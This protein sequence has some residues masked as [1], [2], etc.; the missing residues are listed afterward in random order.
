VSGIGLGLTTVNTGIEHLWWRSFVVA[1]VVARVVGMELGLE[2]GG[3]ADGRKV[4]LSYWHPVIGVVM[5]GRFEVFEK[6]FFLAVDIEFVG[7]AVSA[8]SSTIA[9]VT[10]EAGSQYSI[11]QAGF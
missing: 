9:V 5:F 1:A 10:T 4:D 8:D 6:S 7:L 3:F 2:V 11:S